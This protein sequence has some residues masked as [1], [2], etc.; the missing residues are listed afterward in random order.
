MS[1]SE[2]ELFR[3]VERFCTTEQVKDLLR[4]AKGQKDVRITAENKENLITRNLRD[5]VNSRALSL[6]QVY[7]LVRTAEENGNQHFFYYKPRTKDIVSSLSYDS[8]AKRLWG[9]NWEKKVS[10]FPNVNLKENSFIYADY[11]YWSPA[12][13][14][15]D[16]MLKVYGHMQFDRFTGNEKEENARLYKEF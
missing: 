13:K 5:A 6:E 15:R 3:L 11:R 8:V 12:Q 9:P 14:P 16:W 4:S 10:S 7:T 1:S 2:D